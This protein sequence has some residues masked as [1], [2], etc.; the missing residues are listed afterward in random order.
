MQQCFPCLRAVRLPRAVLLLSTAL[1]Q[2]LSVHMQ[3]A[4][5]EKV[6]P[7]LCSHPDGAAAAGGSEL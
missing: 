5:G 6:C 3:T 4:S 1:F 2:H 7:K